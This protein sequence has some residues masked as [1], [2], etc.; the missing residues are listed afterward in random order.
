MIFFKVQFLP[1]NFGHWEAPNMQ[2]GMGNQ[3]TEEHLVPAN[4]TGLVIG[5]GGETI[6]QIN[7]QSGARAQIVK[8]PPP[9]S[10][11][12]YKIFNIKGRLLL[13]SFHLIIN[14]K[15]YQLISNL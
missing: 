2:G 9:S 13:I 7:A 12:N 6:K 1:G 5:K 8:D 10:D 4:R 11:P 3:I 14:L 15:I